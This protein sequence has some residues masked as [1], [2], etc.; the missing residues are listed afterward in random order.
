MAP[1]LLQHFSLQFGLWERRE[2][3]LD[4]EGAMP[5]SG[6]P[7]VVSCLGQEGARALDVVREYIIGSAVQRHVETPRRRITRHGR[8][9]VQCRR[10]ARSQEIRERLLLGRHV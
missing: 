10:S 2:V 9:E 1:L 6:G 8:Y 5:G 4:F 7:C 3:I